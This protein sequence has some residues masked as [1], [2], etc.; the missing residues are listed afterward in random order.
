MYNLSDYI[1]MGRCSTLLRMIVPSSELF[2][3]S[4]SYEM[5]RGTDLNL[6]HLFTTL[7]PGTTMNKFLV[8]S[9]EGGTRE[10]QCFYIFYIPNYKSTGIDAIVPVILTGDEVKIV[11]SYFAEES[12]QTFL[13]DLCMISDISSDKMATDISTA[14][15]SDEEYINSFYSVVEKYQEECG[16]MVSEVYKQFSHIQEF[17]IT[18]IDEKSKY[19]E[20][21]KNNYKVQQTEAIEY[22]P[23]KPEEFMP[24]VV[25]PIVSEG[26]G[27]ENYST[28]YIKLIEDTK[29]KKTIHRIE[30]RSLKN[31]MVPEYENDVRNKIIVRNFT[32]SKLVILDITSMY[33]VGEGVITI[34]DP[35]ADSMSRCNLNNVLL[36]EEDECADEEFLKSKALSE[37]VSVESL[38]DLKDLYE[39][40]KEV[41]LNVKSD[42]MP[43]I[44]QI[45]GLPRNIAKQIYSFI[46]SIFKAIND[47]EK[48][49][50]LDYQEQ[51]LN[52]NFSE[53]SERMDKMFG[54]LVIFG[55]SMFI[56]TSFV[57][58]LIFFFVG[59]SVH[60][61]LRL[62]A[63]ERM[64]HRMEG[65]LQRL[66]EKIEFARQDMD[67]KAVHNLLKEKEL[68]LF[69]IDRLIET[70]KKLYGVGKKK[71][72]YNN[73]GGEE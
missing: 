22:A 29:T 21:V 73:E 65:A 10:Y 42:L 72:L 5:I 35:N 70:K 25:E 27:E 44:R 54:D 61:K 41:G 17:S 15:A 24:L 16:Y 32:N 47:L 9:T 68:Y 57:I 58:K 1:I 52:D 37:N 23:I 50:A 3:N 18:D 51:V 36:F 46:R 63:I 33:Y 11:R 7:F 4:K 31:D 67:K 13:Y 14:L 69:A 48:D 19:Y 64:E 66:D 2:H 71:S 55:A 12:N 38:S 20:Y 8:C 40:A 6:K 26:T 56:P 59:K 28:V 39:D 60:A 34:M 49:K 30:T 45:A 62:K 43:F 53:L